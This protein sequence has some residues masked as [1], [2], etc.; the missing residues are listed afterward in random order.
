MGKPHFTSYHGL[1]GVSVT[2]AALL[3]ALM[4]A[5]AFR[6]LGMLQK[7]P[8]QLQPALK[9]AHTLAGAFVWLAALCNVL[10]GLRT[11]GAGP[12][13]T[14]HYGQGVA[15]LILAVAQGALLLQRR[16]APRAEQE[17]AGKLV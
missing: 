2:A 4:G 14:L 15:V 1:L 7:L 9:R 10:L 11:H 3:V 16:P 8:S 13:I 5:G 17:D 12:R 6:R